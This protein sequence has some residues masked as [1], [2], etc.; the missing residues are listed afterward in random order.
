[1]RPGCG[2]AVSTSS[3]RWGDLAPIA[4]WLCA[5]YVMSEQLDLGITLMINGLDARLAAEG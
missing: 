1:M 5:H 4:Q 2:R 3:E